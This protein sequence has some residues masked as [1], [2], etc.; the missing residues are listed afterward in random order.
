MIAGAPSTM[1]SPCGANCS[2]TLTF[3][4]PSLQCAPLEIN[5]DILDENFAMGNPAFEGLVF[6]PYLALSLPAG[7]VD[8]SGSILPSRFTF[9][10]YDI[11]GINSSNF[12]HPAIAVRANIL[13]CTPAST[14]YTA[15][16]N[17]TSN[18]LTTIISND[19]VRDIT[20]LSAPAQGLDGVFFP[21]SVS[22]QGLDSGIWVFEN[23]PLLW[24]DG[25]LAWYGNLQL[26]AIINSMTNSL[27]GS[28]PVSISKPIRDDSSG[29]LPAAWGLG[30]G[31]WQLD[32][33]WSDS[34]STL[35]TG[36]VKVHLLCVN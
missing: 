13:K 3:Q 15:E 36:I 11:L 23:E 16:Y 18:V 32:V 22:Q 30:D 6:D 1:T 20:N 12:D 31:V 17:Y 28:Y 24:T 10:T 33:G 21:G 8:P 34:Q 14:T 19:S 29:T 26:M 27:N 35:P 5:Y 2:Y 7:D 4:A 9:T 25:W